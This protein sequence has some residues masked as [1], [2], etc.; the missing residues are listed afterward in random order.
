MAEKTE[1]VE[2]RELIEKATEAGKEYTA[3]VSAAGLAG[4]SSAFELQ[5]SA[6]AAGRS[7]TDASIAASKAFA[8]QWTKAVREGQ[9]Q[10]TK[11]AEASVQLVER[12]FETK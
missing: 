12:T 11:L 10:A 4:L 3:S 5:N 7:V 2:P 1:G 6:I 9:A 8:D